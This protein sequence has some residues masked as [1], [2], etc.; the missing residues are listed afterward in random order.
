[1]A[2]TQDENGNYKRTVRCGHCYEIGHNKSSCPQKKQMH[3]DKVA[4]YEKQLAEDNFIDDWERNYAKRVLSQ[5]KTS[6][7]KSANRGKHRKCSYCKDEG[8]TRR[9]CSFRKGD[10]N[11]WVDE[12]I[13]AR[14]KFVESMT[15]TGFGIGALAYRKDYYSSDS[16]ELVMITRVLWHMITH[17]VAVGRDNHYADVC[18]GQ[19]LAP[20]NY[21]PNG[22]TWQL[23]LPASVSNINNDELPHRFEE[24]CPEIVAPS[25]ASVPEDFLTKESAMVAAK[26]SQKFNDSRPYNYRGVEYND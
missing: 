20:D 7:E 11:N 26:L 2:Y 6:L 25:P 12:C 24:R 21:Y 23:Q 22:R 16:K 9:T 10:M 14:E 15:A 17:E 5:H 4:E 1:M 19:S 13:A 18:Y 3:K 8:H